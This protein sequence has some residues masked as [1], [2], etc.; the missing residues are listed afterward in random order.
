MDFFFSNIKSIKPSLYVNE[1]YYLPSIPFSVAE[2][3]A[4]LRERTTDKQH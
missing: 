1:Q 2:T 3:V 4:I